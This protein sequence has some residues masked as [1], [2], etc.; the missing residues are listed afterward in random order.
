MLS[1]FFEELFGG[2][3]ATNHGEVLAMLLEGSTQRFG[4]HGCPATDNDRNSHGGDP[5]RSRHEQLSRG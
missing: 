2:N 1:Y 4:E 3:G 5:L